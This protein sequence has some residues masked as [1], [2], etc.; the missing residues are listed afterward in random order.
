MDIENREKS[1]HNKSGSV[2]VAKPKDWIILMLR[3]AS[4]MATF[5][6]T[7]VMALNKET[8]TLV[9]S[10]VGNTPIRVPLTAKFQHTP[11]FV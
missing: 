5:S 1:I 2:A 10:T 11:A 8:K 3:L 9:V 7:I 6:A 4:F